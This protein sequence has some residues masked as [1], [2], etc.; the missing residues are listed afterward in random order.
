M[1]NASSARS[2]VHQDRE[3]SKSGLDALPHVGARPLV[4]Y[5]FSEPVTRRTAGTMGWDG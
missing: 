1:K 2:E 3:I 4:F 5:T